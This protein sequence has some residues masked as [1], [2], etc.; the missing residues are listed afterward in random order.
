M[1]T[2]LDLP[3]KLVD[4]ALKLSKVKTKTAI[5]TQ[6]LEDFIRKNHI[7]ELKN[8]RGKFDLGMDLDSLRDRG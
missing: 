8:Y 3:E 2:T 5:I 7:Q 4:E 6:A 1:R